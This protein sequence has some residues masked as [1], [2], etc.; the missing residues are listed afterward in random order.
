MSAFSLLS[1]SSIYIASV[2]NVERAL[3][4]YRAIVYSVLY[5][6]AFLFTY[7]ILY[8]FT[9][10]IYLDYFHY[11]YGIELVNLEYF[12]WY[13]PLV[14]IPLYLMRRYVRSTWFSLG[15][16][17][18]FGVFWTAWILIGFPQ[19]FTVGTLYYS[20]FVSITDYRNTSLFLNYGSKLVLAGLFISLVFHPLVAQSEGTGT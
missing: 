2:R 3:G 1:I 10:P 11:P 19:Y 7:E 9:W 18:A 6:V 15:F 5:C 14:V 12:A 16:A 8:H 20:P 4:S 13:L 17:S